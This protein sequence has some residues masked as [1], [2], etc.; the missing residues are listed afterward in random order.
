MPQADQN[1]SHEELLLQKTEITEEKITT[2]MGGQSQAA[3][4]NE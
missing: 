4:R 2:H 1:Y 3:E